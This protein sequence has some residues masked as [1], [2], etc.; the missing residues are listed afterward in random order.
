MRNFVVGSRVTKFLDS[1]F[2]GTVI[3]VHHRPVTQWMVGGASSAEEV[4]MVRL[5]DGTVIEVVSRDL[6]G[7]D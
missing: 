3:S 5:P 4:A 7:I 6:M 2:K 1:S